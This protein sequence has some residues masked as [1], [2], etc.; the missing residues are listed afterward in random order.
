[1]M[2]QSST[3]REEEAAR[4]GLLEIDRATFREGFNRRPFV[5]R[6]HLAGHPL[7]TLTRLIEL[8]RT[9]PH[10]CIRY[11]AGD[12]PVSS[13]LYGGP[14]TGLSIEETIR[15]IEERN[16]WLV[17]KFVERD[18]AYRELL[19]VCLDE[20]QTFSEPLE[21]GMYG[22]AGFI[23]ISSPSSITPYHLDPEY[24]FLLQIRGRKSINIFDAEDR[25]VLS[26]QELE[27]YFLAADKYNLSYRDE[28]QSRAAV[29]ELSGGE[30]LHFP[31]TAPH[32]VKNGEEVSVSFSITFRTPVADRRARIYD[33][34]G[35]LRRYGVEPTPYGRSAL[36]DAAKLYA[37]RAW[38]LAG[39]ITRR[40]IFRFLWNE[41]PA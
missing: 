21:P 18:S 12:L 28:Y 15:Q 6:H 2:E 36:R 26:E 3:E 32:W 14:P 4:R 5:I 19:D 20:I 22:R 33:L 17:L 1:M 31:V 7:F 10:D 13:G 27:K 16:S 35:R 8:A 40:T 24:N 9:L 41:R 34:N 39:R 29:Y 11:G 37:A 30:G 25:S 23:F 38:G